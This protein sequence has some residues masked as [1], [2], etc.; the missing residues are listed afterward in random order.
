MISNYRLTAE[1]KTEPVYLCR[2]GVEHTGDY[3]IYDYGH[4]MCFHDAPLWNID[5]WHFVCSECGKPFTVED[6]SLPMERVAEMRAEYDIR[7]GLRG[8]YASKLAPRL[9]W[10][11]EIVPFLQ[12]LHP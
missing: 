8:K 7:G 5:Y 2:C 3:A 4:H 9:S 6:H 10:W 12:A 11:Q 1:G